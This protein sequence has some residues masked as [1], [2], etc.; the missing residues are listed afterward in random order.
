MDKPKRKLNIGILSDSPFLCTGYATIS[1]TIANALA[2]QGHNVYFLANNYLGQNLLPGST[3]ED[4][5]KLNFHILGQG[6]EGYF[7]DLLPIYT[8]MYNMDVL[9]ILFDTFMLYNWLMQLD[10]SPSKV[11]FYYPSDGGGHMP[12]GCENILKF[13]HKPVAMAKFGRDQVKKV[14]G[15]DTD[16][17][18]HAID[19]KQFYPLSKEDKL[20]YRAMFGISE[21]TFVVGTVA[22][23]QGRKMMDRTIKSFAL[24]AKKNPKAILF[25]HT[26]PDD[27]A[28]VFHMGSLIHRYGIQNRVLFSG[29]KYFKGFD[30]SQMNA[31]Y[32]IMD[33]FLLTTSGE[34]FGIPII[35]AQSAGIPVL[36]TDYTTTRELVKETKGG[37]CIDLVGDT[38]EENPDVHGNE[39][40]DGTLTGSWNVERGMCSIKDCAKKLQLLEENPMLREQLGKNGREAMIKSYSWDVVMPQW[41]K[42]IEELGT[43]I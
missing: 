39:L 23:N 2:E 35:E 3:F 31:I 7:K 25:M 13:V 32:N 38:E 17:I 1:K 6:R 11:I 42:L 34:G 21:D 18:P 4:G 12:L 28:Q 40:L 24:Y 22:R 14:H 30:Y 41:I 10:L 27:A 26:D 20:K 8:K 33:V 15:I 43:K 9:F 16:Y 37:M 5:Y 19:V 36:V 29:M